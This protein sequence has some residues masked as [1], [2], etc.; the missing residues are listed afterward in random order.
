M[1]A[2]DAIKLLNQNNPDMGKLVKLV[3]LAA[4]LQELGLRVP[5]AKGAVVTSVAARLWPYKLVAW[6][7]E[8]LLD[9]AAAATTETATTATQ[10]KD[11][12]PPLM[13]QLN[14]QTHT[15]VTSLQQQQ[16]QDDNDNS[17]WTILHTPRG[18]IKAHKTILATNAYTSFLLPQL[19]NLILPVRGQMSALLFPSFSS[20]SSSSSSSTTKEE[21]E[22]AY[23]TRNASFAFIGHG[24]DDYLIQRPFE[25]Q[26][27]GR[28]GGG[29]LM[30]GGGKE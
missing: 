15:P 29:H 12:Y 4:E 3:T 18:T 21:E 11:D 16:H 28:G 30:F 19:G 7:W 10:T 5:E 2:S 24:M 14:L 9:A 6:L 27:G 22:E 23:K 13:M 1:L 20:S 8:Y 25:K 26:G 17:S